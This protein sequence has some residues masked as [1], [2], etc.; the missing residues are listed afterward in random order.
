MDV[1]MDLYLAVPLLFTVVAVILASLFVRLRA[2]GGD[3]AAEA[4]PGEGATE[5]AERA[6]EGEGAEK[7]GEGLTAEGAPSGGKEGSR[8]PVEEIG[9]GE[10]KAKGAAER[11]E[12]QP[13]E[14]AARTAAAETQS[15]APEATV[16]SRAAG[17][18]QEDEEEDE[19]KEEDQDWEKEKL[20]VK[21]P[22]LDDAPDEQISFKYS[23]GKLRGSQYKTMMTKEELEE[24]QRVQR[25]QLTAIF[26]LMEENSKTFGEMSEGDVMEQLKLYDM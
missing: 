4:A 9:A 20:V 18:R 2:A 6:A 16:P 12:Q 25:E 10:G 7:A 11:E 13:E 26:R 3:K 19:S 8:V 1:A 24:E 21:E 15:P 17:E 23:P 22:D 14:A 5:A